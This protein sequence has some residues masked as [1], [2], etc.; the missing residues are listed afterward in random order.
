MSRLSNLPRVPQ[1][2]IGS[3]KRISINHGFTICRVEIS[4]SSYIE[5]LPSASSP[6]DR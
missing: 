3:F 2:I 6:L 5:H 1:P 4:V